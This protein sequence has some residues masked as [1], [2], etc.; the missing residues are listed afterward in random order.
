MARKVISFLLVGLLL[1]AGGCSFY[2]SAGSSKATEPTNNNN[3][4]GSPG[5]LQP[6]SQTGGS[7]PGGWICFIGKN[8]S[9]GGFLGL[10]NPRTGNERQVAGPAYSWLAPLSGRLLLGS[11][12]YY[13]KGRIAQT[14]GAVIRW[15]PATGAVR[16]W[17]L[18]FSA[19]HGGSM[20]T[21]GGFGAVSGKGR[22]AIYYFRGGGIG[23]LYNFYTSDFKAD[24]AY[25]SLNV[26]SGNPVYFGGMSS[27]GPPVLA[28]SSEGTWLLLGATPSQSGPG[29]VYGLLSPGG[30]IQMDTALNIWHHLVKSA[31]FS[32][33]GRYLA[34]LGDG[35]GL[36]VA[37]GNGYPVSMNS[38]SGFLP[39]Y[40]VAWS[41][42]GHYL[43]A[44]SRQYLQ[45]FQFTA[46]P[47]SSLSVLRSI[48]LPPGTRHWA[49]IPGSAAVIPNPTALQGADA[50]LDRLA[51]SAAVLVPAPAGVTPQ[52]VVRLTTAAG[53]VSLPVSR[54]E[55]GPGNSQWC[56]VP[57]G[58]HPGVWPGFST[59]AQGN[60]VVLPV[61][62]WLEHGRYTVTVS[63]PG[64]SIIRRIDF[65]AALA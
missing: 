39:V 65:L 48:K 10:V 33:D 18:H 31:A 9:G 58:F 1:L 26:P 14:N 19:P 40:K 24:P 34:L 32:P 52:V 3:L 35:G 25:A 30:R 60:W 63:W 29:Y 23:T 7:G 61:S 44:G 12:S 64:G 55:D 42:G 22:L 17:S 51:A 8:K 46:A 57:R 37:A 59:A 11:F 28:C 43:A 49:S 13:Q 2:P 47:N 4:P 45:V 41:P 56:L 62:G 38:G 20:Y 36:W 21:E 16:P 53:E 50:K 6:P 27:Y 15:N 5:Q 54:W